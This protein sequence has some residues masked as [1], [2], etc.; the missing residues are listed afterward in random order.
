MRKVILI[1]LLTIVTSSYS[2]TYRSLEINSSG[3]A[4]TLKGTLAPNFAANTLDNKEVLLKG[5]TGQ[6]VLLHFWS[7]SCAACFKE[8]PELNEIVKKYSKEKFILISLMDDSKDDLLKMLNM[9]D[10]GYS[11]KKPIYG[12]DKIDFQII[13]NMKAVMKLYSEEFSFPK[14]FIL[15]QNGIITFY[16]SGYA[17][18]RG[19][20]GELTTKDMFV[21][22]IDRLLTDGH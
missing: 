7:L 19:F 3:E 21:K 14:T 4:H 11:M 5:L 9:V 2:Q 1:L 13:P 20:I 18:K 6:I 15:D 10:S 12:N 16:I 17:P 22:E 8:L